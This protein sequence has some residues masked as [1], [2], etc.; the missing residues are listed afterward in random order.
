MFIKQHK[1]FEIEMKYNSFCLNLLQ[2]QKGAIVFIK[3]LLFFVWFSLKIENKYCF[4]SEIYHFSL[5]LSDFLMYLTR[6]L[7][8]FDMFRLTYKEE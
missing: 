4:W 1:Y 6:E 7:L 8:N 5:S 3:F 2:S